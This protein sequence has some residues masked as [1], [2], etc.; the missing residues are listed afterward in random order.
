M[1]MCQK[2]REEE[3]RPSRITLQTKLCCKITLWFLDIIKVKTGRKQP[4]KMIPT[5]D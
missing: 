1:S 2:R 3:M 5:S 4:I